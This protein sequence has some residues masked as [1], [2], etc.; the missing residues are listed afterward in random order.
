[1]LF[2]RRTPTNQANNILISPPLLSDP[3]AFPLPPPQHTRLHRDEHLRSVTPKWRE[4]CASTNSPSHHIDTP[5]SDMGAGGSPE[6]QSTG[7]IDVDC[8]GSSDR[9]TAAGIPGG[10]DVM[11]EGDRSP[12]VRQQEFQVGGGERGGGSINITTKGSKQFYMSVAP[13]TLSLSL[14][15]C[16]R[17]PFNLERCALTL[18]GHG[19]Y[20]TFC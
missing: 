1:M 17:C 7:A 2:C 15:C 8:G 14:Y 5:L 6:N 13:N 12:S 3:R 11:R 10:A 4:D 9:V 20:Q 16:R 19:N 18:L